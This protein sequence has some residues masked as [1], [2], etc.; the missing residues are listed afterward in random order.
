MVTNSNYHKQDKIYFFSGI[1][2][3]W[4]NCWNKA[5]TG[6]EWQHKG[7]CYCYFFY[8]LPVWLLNLLQQNGMSEAKV[9]KI[10]DI[11][12]SHLIFSIVTGFW[13]CPFCN[14][15]GC[16][17]SCKGKVWICCKPNSIFTRH[18]SVL[19]CWELLTATYLS[20]FPS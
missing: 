9:K 2:C 1:L 19:Q 12:V 3:L 14:K 11:I 8:L 6:P 15:R 13:V 18:I 17:K 7:Y 20:W 5:D 10:L 16:R 4:Q